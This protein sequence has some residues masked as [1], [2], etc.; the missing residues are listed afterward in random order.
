MA[1]AFQGHLGQKRREVGTQAHVA[2]W[3]VTD[4]GHNIKAAGR[5]Q[6]RLNTVTCQPSIIE[7][8]DGFVR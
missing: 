8:E 1:T 2:E 3:A 6:R 4:T 5:G 7:A